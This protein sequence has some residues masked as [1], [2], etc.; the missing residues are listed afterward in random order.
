MGDNILT[1]VNRIEKRDV[2]LP[3]IQRSF[4][5]DEDQIYELFDSLV[6][7]YPIGSLLF[8][9]AIGGEQDERQLVYHEFVRYYRK[10]QPLPQSTMLLRGQEKTFVLDGQQRLQSLYLGL[11]GT[12]DG[13]ELYV[14]LKG[15]TSSEDRENNIEYYVRFRGSRNDVKELDRLMVRVKDFIFLPQERF[16]T[17]RRRLMDESGLAPASDAYEKA[18]DVLDQVRS[19]LLQPEVI[20]IVTIDAQARSAEYECDLILMF[21]NGHILQVAPPL[22]ALIVPRYIAHVCHS[23]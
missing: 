22:N 17:Y 13:R 12:Y 14:D 9:K 19:K 21:P 15:G 6:R 3:D 18:R 10:D 16:T 1:L 23:K 2:V 20:P 7:G 8:W 4:V 5:W 11:D